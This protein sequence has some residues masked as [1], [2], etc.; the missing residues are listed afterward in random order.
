MKQELHLPGE[1]AQISAC[2]DLPGGRCIQPG[3]GRRAATKPA[4]RLAYSPR[5][6]GVFL[7]ECLLRTASKI[8]PSW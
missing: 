7:S 4:L 5:S 8:L 3:S 2:W 6:L 1:D